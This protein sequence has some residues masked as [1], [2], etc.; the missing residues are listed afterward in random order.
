MTDTLA[1][2]QVLERIKD[3]LKSLLAREDH[4]AVYAVLAHA[5]LLVQRAPF[6][7][8]SDHVAFYCRTHDPWYVK[9]QKMQILATIAMPAN[10]YEIVNELTEYARDISPT[11]AR[12]AVRAVGQIALSVPDV[13]GI[14]ERLLAF[15]ESGSE[16]LIAETLI[17]MKDL[18]RRYPD[19]GEVVVPSAAAQL[20]P[21]DVA[22]SKARAACVWILGQYG[23]HVKVRKRG[24]TGVPRLHCAWDRQASISTAS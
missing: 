20:N 21:G 9:K 15:L 2:V 4:A 16:H 14:V 22:D 12:E 1:W 6:V 5:A 17:Q 24:S 10:V 19:M 3:P 18:L 7:F 13:S 11:M 23:M 8:E